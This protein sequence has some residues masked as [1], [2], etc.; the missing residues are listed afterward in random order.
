MA[1][2]IA[3]RGRGDLPRGPFS[4]TRVP[5]R[6]SPFIRKMRELERISPARARSIG[7]IVDVILDERKKEGA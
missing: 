3:F 1:R 6:D 5:K 2:V 7:V 4:A